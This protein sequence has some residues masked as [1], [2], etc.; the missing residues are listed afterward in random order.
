MR[1]HT[2]FD[3]PDKEPWAFGPK[4]EDI[5]R[6][7]IELRYELLPYIYNV[8][9]QTSETGVPALRPLF[10]EFPGD[11]R[12]ANI[13]DE[14]MFGSDLLAA[15]VLWD[16][17]TNRQVYLPA[18]DWYDYWTGKHYPGT[19]D[20][21]TVAAPLDY[22]PL[23]VARRRHSF[24]RQPVVQNTGAMPGNPLRVLIV[25]AADSSA[26]L[27]EDDGKSL[28]YRNGGF[29]TRQFHQTR[30][31]N[32]VTVDVAAMEGG[33]RPAKRDLILELWQGSEPKT[34]TEQ[35]ASGGAP[36]ALPRVE[37]ASFATAARGWTF[38]S[39]LLRVKDNDSFGSVRFGVQK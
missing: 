17:F 11:E 23:F 19:F 27:Y 15:P 13:D 1:S 8:M 25:P 38:D 3:T 6:R 22:I 21:I 24:F 14:F 18:G 31:A 30:G 36:E 29:M 26:T 7:T 34:V 39:G 28:A 2:E 20:H 5:N 37:A 33:F 4:F 32:Q 35:A 12:T 9:Q 16:G 10:L